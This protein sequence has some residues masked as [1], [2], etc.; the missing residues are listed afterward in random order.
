M[1]ASVSKKRSELLESI[2]M[3]L[4]KLMLADYAYILDENT[5]LYGKGIG[6]DSIEVLQ[7]VSAIEEEFDLTID[8]DELLPDYFRTA[9]NLITFL[10][11]ILK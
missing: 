8:E 11:G 6:L 4:N 5:G 1:K 2:E 9:G 7:L 10:E 3:L